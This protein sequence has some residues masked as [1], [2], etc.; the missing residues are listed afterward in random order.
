MPVASQQGL[1]L[2]TATL[3]HTAAMIFSPLRKAVIAGAGILAVGAAGGV[4]VHAG[5][6]SATLTATTASPSPSTS[7]GNAG[8]NAACAPSRLDRAARQ[9]LAIAATV[10]GKPQAEIEAQLRAGRTLDQIAG[11][12]AATI[13]QQALAKLKARLDQMV[14][15]G[16]LTA[17]RE[18]ALLARATTALE[19]AMSSDLSQYLKGEGGS[20][21]D[22]RGLLR[23]VVKVTAEKTGLTQ[24]QV[25]QDLRNGQSIDQIAGAKAAE[26]KAAV[27]QIEQQR[28]STRLDTLMSHQG[29]DQGGRRGARGNAGAGSGAGNDTGS[30]LQSDLFGA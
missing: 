10:L 14:S 25:L 12:K 2:L 3:G 20:D 27:L 16:K 24:Q 21:C 22:V 17:D 9:V 19:K 23:L 30:A 15:S 1:R 26:V 7:T 4:A 13:E 5:S 6:T 8:R 18:T 29:L 11:D 28:L